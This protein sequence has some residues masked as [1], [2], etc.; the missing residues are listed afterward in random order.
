[1]PPAAPEVPRA[2]A[3]YKKAPAGMGNPR[4]LED[5]ESGAYLLIIFLS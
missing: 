2:P 3:V 4:A 1:M 5:W